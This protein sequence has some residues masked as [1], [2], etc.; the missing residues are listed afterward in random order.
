MDNL[1]PEALKQDNTYTK[2]I[3]DR[4]V[5]MLRMSPGA[6]QAQAAP[7]MG[8]MAGQA[9]QTLQNIPYQR[10]LQEMQAQGMQPMS[11]QQFM[12]QNGQ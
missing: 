2:A 6:G 10:Y 11:Q 12:M 3:K 7:A 8:G 4:L 9:Q 1:S 5:Q